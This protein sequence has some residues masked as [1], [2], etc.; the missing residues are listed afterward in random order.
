M[1]TVLFTL[2]VEA[3]IFLA[4]VQIRL[5]FKEEL[6]KSLMLACIESYLVVLLHIYS[7][8]VFSPTEHK[9]TSFSIACILLL[10]YII[11]GFVDFFEVF[12]FA[13]VGMIPLAIPGV[14]I[15]IDIFTKK[16]YAWLDIAF[17]ISH[18]I[19]LA[20]SVTAFLVWIYFKGKSDGE[21][22]AKEEYEAIKTKKEATKVLLPKP[23]ELTKSAQERL[24]E[25]LPSQIAESVIREIRTELPKGND[26]VSV[27]IHNEDDSQ[28]RMLFQ[29][30]IRELF[31]SLMT[32]IT[33]ADNAMR[34]IS[35]SKGDSD[36]EDTLS[37]NLETIDNSLSLNKALLYAYRGLALVDFTDKNSGITIK[38]F[39]ADTIKSLNL[40]HKK[41]VSVLL[42]DSQSFAI[43][44]YSTEMVIALL[45]PLLQNAVEA[46][47]TDGT[48]CV[49]EF[50]HA[51]HLE[52]VVINSTQEPVST[53]D[54][55]TDKFSTKK[56]DSSGHE[57]IGLAA[58][59][60]I[61]KELQISFDIYVEEDKVVATLSFPRRIEKEIF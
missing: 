42:D 27:S 11:S 13:F 46:S 6:K 8:S 58:V 7:S 45:L 36:F 23:S 17:K 38:S 26:I 28:S 50:S 39:I 31:H 5:Y 47:P 52:I 29:S 10:S 25:D 40:Q 34:L 37:E 9:W 35:A 49:Q 54:L 57:G 48:I 20:A 30:Q 41:Q 59:R 51:N 61:A 15:L 2:G 32:P 43:T 16:D 18:W 19:L 44:G 4:V 33:A 24:L 12:E 53:E 60:N 56:E 21:N 14:F 1:G 55:N 22:K 3:L